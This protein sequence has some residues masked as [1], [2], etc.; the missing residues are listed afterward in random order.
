MKNIAFFCYNIDESG[1]LERVTTLVAN[2]L[3]NRTENSVTIISL[4]GNKSTFFA[5]DPN[6]KIHYISKDSNLNYYLAM[7]QIRKILIHSKIDNVIVVDTLLTLI[8]L[9]SSIGLNLNIIGWEH[10]SFHSSVVGKKRLISR[11]MTKFFF[12][13]VVVLTDRDKKNWTKRILYKSKIVTIE[14]PSPFKVPE[15][16]DKHNCTYALAVGRLRYEKGFDLLIDA[17]YLAE[18]KLPS[19]VKLII[20]GEGEEKYKL[21][22]KIRLLRLQESII[23]E[24]FTEEISS[25]YSKARIY[26]LSSRTEALPMVLI[27]ALSFSIPLLAFDCYTGPREIIEQGNNGF[28]I[29]EN[30]IES[31]AEKIVNLFTISDKELASLSH[32]AYLSSFKYEISNIIEKWT[33]MLE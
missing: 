33:N 29:N 19:N 9:P 5:L 11:W 1:G 17:W 4:N 2:E 7:N 6:I 14:N 3:N 31:Y 8:L 25:Y 26:C 32:N 21:E 12:D 24:N 20:V 13:K 16:L 30:D 28:I 23:I 27:E 22:E 15:D 10:Y 18:K